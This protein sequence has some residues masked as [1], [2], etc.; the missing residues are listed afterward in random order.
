MRRADGESEDTT[1]CSY[2]MCRARSEQCGIVHK[3]EGSYLYSPVLK[4][5]A[6]CNGEE[7]VRSVDL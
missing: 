7:R 5:E 6:A 1:E 3:N 2:A 4:V